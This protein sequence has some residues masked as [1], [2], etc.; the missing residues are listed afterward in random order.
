MENLEDILEE[1]EGEEIK[2]IPWEE[3]GEIGILKGIYLTIKGALFKPRDFFSKI[4]PGGI[5][6]AGLYAL[7]IALFCYFLNL[8]WIGQKIP[9]NHLLFIPLISL[10]FFFLLETALLHTGIAIFS[11]NKYPFSTTFKVCAYSESVL[12][13]SV[14]PI[15]GGIVSSIWGLVIT[16]IGLSRAHN[17]PVKKALLSAIFSII[18]TAIIVFIPGIFYLKGVNDE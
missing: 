5:K 14:V 16:V 2:N 18:I 8:I 9:L 4:K 7:I 17:I 10:I 3:R 6:N 12:V 15:V 1:S 13:F 11:P